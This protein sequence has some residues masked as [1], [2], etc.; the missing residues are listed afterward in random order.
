M[1]KSQTSVPPARAPEQGRSGRGWFQMPH[2]RVTDGGEAAS[3]GLLQTVWT[4]QV[5]QGDATCKCNRPLCAGRLGQTGDKMR[6]PAQRES[7][8]HLAAVL[9]HQCDSKSGGGGAG[10]T[11]AGPWGQLKAA[12]QA[13]EYRRKQ[14]EE[15]GTQGSPT[16]AGGRAWVRSRSHLL[17]KVCRWAGLCR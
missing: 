5:P 13:R 7:K 8:T 6:P 9:P 14:A 1:G 16:G 10:G 17:G 11:L 12:S 15:L 4:D 3:S 2:P